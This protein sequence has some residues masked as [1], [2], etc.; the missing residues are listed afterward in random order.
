MWIFYG[1][2]AEHC[3]NKMGGSGGHV[4][5]PWHPVLVPIC[6]DDSPTLSIPNARQQQAQTTAHAAR[7]AMPAGTGGRKSMWA[8]PRVVPVYSPGKH[9]TVG[10]P[11]TSESNNI[12]QDM[13]LNCSLHIYHGP[14]WSPSGVHNECHCDLTGQSAHLMV[15]EIADD[16]RVLTA[17]EQKPYLC[18][19]ISLKM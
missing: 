19:V 7:L 17:D 13:P 2:L 9:H 10:Q 18:L 3:R 15:T 6:I 12:Y 5:Q 1:V 11:S 16:A 14:Y 8:E 4:P